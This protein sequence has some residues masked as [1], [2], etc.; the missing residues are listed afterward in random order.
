ME[1]SLNI[2]TGI[3]AR[4]LFALPLIMF[5]FGHFTNANAMA[6]MMLANVPGNVV[7]VYLTGVALL[8]AALAIIIKKKAALATLLLGFMLLLFAL[9]IHMPGM[10]SAD[11]MVAMTSMSSFFK[12]IGLSGG[13]FFMSGVFRKEK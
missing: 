1:K 6:N 12:D 13:A 4:V 10:G 7:L 2:L 11:E 8:A 3:V 9:I 5:G